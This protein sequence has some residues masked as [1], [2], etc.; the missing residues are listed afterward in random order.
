MTSFILAI[1]CLSNAEKHT[2]YNTNGVN[3]FDT[4][5]TGEFLSLL[6]QNI[7]EI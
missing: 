7:M 5:R 4:S 6:L 1:F 3:L 2:C